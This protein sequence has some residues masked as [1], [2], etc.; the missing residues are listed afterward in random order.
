MKRFVM[1]ISIILLLLI[2]I[3]FYK[4]KTRAIECWWGVMYP[5]LSYLPVEEEQEVARISSS[6]P[7]YIYVPD[8]EIKTDFYILKLFKKV[9]NFSP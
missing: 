1:F 8:T 2:G 6:D 9:F 4:Y 7:D 3:S 5:C